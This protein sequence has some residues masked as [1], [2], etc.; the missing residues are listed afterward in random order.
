MA[1]RGPSLYYFAAAGLAE[2]TGVFLNVLALGLGK[3]SVV[4]PLYG[5]APIFV[6]LLSFFFLRGLEILNKRLVL[7]SVLIVL[8]IYLIIAFK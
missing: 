7:G 4:V 8:G 5:T 3:V 6:L 2:N 1:C